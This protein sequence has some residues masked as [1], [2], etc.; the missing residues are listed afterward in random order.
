MFL[1]FRKPLTDL[2]QSDPDPISNPDIPD[3][4][5]SNKVN[6]TW[7]EPYNGSASFYTIAISDDG[8]L[9]VNK[10][11][12]SPSTNATL[13]YGRRYS[14]EITTVFYNLKGFPYRRNFTICNYMKLA[15]FVFWLTTL[16]CT[17]WSLNACLA[18]LFRFRIVDVFMHVRR[19]ALFRYYF[20]R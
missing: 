7:S 10:T 2:L 14:V 6:F 20:L 16:L 15:A 3:T 4:F 11:E 18:S 9:V 5:E 8:I 12:K 17:Y 1:L 13:T 19:I